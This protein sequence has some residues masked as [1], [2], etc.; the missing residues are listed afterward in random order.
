[1]T[2]VE[3]IDWSIG[4]LVALGGLF[5]VIAGA[6][7]MMA[8]GRAL[9]Q[10]PKTPYDVVIDRV[11]SLEESNATISSDLFRIRSQVYRLAGVLTREVSTLIKWH[12]DGRTPPTPDKEIAI[13]K[14]II[15]EIQEDNK[16][17][18]KP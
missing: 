11:K 8:E 10:P 15:Y 13:I 5:A 16:T 7:K 4:T 3:L 2:G 18:M 9:K 1:M 12:E 14:E 6:M 17:S